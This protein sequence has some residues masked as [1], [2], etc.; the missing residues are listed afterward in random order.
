MRKEQIECLHDFGSRYDRFYS[1]GDTNIP[2]SIFFEEEN[3]EVSTLFRD[4]EKLL[5]FESLGTYYYRRRSKKVVS[6]R[7]DRIWMLH[8]N[9]KNTGV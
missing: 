9:F 8:K 3:R 5:Q 2:S 7:I 6:E 1:I 4:A